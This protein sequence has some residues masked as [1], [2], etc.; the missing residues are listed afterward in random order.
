M[1]TRI[2]SA[3]ALAFRPFDERFIKDLIR[4]RSRAEGQWK[5]QCH[6]LPSFRS[7]TG[8]PSLQP[9]L[10][11]L[12]DQILRGSSRDRNRVHYLADSSEPRGCRKSVARRTALRGRDGPHSSIL[13]VRCE[14][15]SFPTPAEVSVVRPARLT[16]RAW[17][18]L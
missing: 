9:F 3:R 16:L 17:S 6:F 10:S 15:D 5:S 8:R 12:G 13:P 7:R 4:K 1:R 2:F 11:C 14:G 18:C